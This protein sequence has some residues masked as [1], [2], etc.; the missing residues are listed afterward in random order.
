V[1]DKKSEL[2][3]VERR[4]EALQNERNAI[5]A[6]H[7]RLRENMKAL[8]VGTVAFDLTPP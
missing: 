6:D 5:A 3:A 8:L 1:L 4:F 7:Q 2:S